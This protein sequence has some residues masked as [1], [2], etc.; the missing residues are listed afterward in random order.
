[1]SILRSFQAVY[2]SGVT[3]TATT[4]SASAVI[5]TKVTTSG[6][7][8]KSVVVTNQDSTNH[9]YVKV[10]R[11]TQTATSASYDVPP[12]AQVCLSKGEYDDQMGVLSAASTVAYHAIVGEGF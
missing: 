5:D 2:G 11:G 12:G 4:S 9:L 3:G 1:M 8:S 7:G 10:G 6:G